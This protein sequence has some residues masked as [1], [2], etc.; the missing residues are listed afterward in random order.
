MNSEPMNDYKVRRI[1]LLILSVLLVVIIVLFVQA[2]QPPQA[3]KVTQAPPSISQISE[4]PGYVDINDVL[5]NQPSA[6]P[7]NTPEP[8][9]TPEPTP[10]PTP[11]PRPTE[12]VSLR[13]GD[14][15]DE[16][17]SMQQRLIELGYLKQ[18]DADGSFG[19]GTKAAVQEFQKNNGLAPDG[20]AG[21]ET[22]TK[23][24]SGDAR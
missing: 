12:I 17:R 4:Q 15:K 3:P 1:V 24:F 8:S 23:M 22:L 20:V 16:V 13:K 11:T 18:G 2:V 5:N 7:E 6:A 19:K 21:R 10:V 14:K 9:P